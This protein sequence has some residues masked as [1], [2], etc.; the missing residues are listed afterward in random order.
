MKTT[1][2]ILF[3]VLAIAVIATSLYIYQ[4]HFN[5]RFTE[6]TPGKVYKSGVIP[7]DKIGDYLKENHI[8]TVIDLRMGS[9]VDPLNATSNKEITQERDAVNEI[10]GATYVNIP[11]H[12]IPNQENLIQFY[13]ILDNP[14]AY[15]VLIHCHHGI[16]RAGLYT[17]LYQVKYEGYSNEEAREMTSWFVPFSSF[18]NGTPKGEWLKKYNSNEDVKIVAIPETIKNNN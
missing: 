3:S 10:E 17:A 5:Y 13:K 14:N 15:P 6:V 9:V 12:Q 18:D 11:S 16:G 2:K 8:K 7:P 1:N 4:V